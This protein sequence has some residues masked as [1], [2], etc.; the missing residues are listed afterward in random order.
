M[1]KK[2]SFRNYVKATNF[3]FFNKGQCK[4]FFV[5][6]QSDKTDSIILNVQTNKSSFL[7]VMLLRI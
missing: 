7:Y 2:A 6:T 5:R 4:L 3:Y 1:Q